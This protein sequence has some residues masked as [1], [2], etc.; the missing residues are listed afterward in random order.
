MKTP[1][2]RKRK[3]FTLVEILLSV[4]ILALVV[5]FAS[6]LIGGTQAVSSIAGR[7]SDADSEAR[8]IFNRMAIDFNAIARRTDVNFY[9]HHPPITSGSSINDSFYFFSEAPGYFANGDPQGSASTVRD[10]FSLVGYRVSDQISGNTRFQLERLGRG[11]HWATVTS[12]TSLGLPCMPQTIVATFSTAISDPYN[13]SSNLAAS[14]TNSPNV[15]E[16]DV[17][18]D[19]VFRLA[20]CFLLSDGTLSNIPVIQSNGLTNTVTATGPPSATNDSNSSPA[21]SAGSRWYDTNAEIAYQCITPSAGAAVW[22]PLGLQDVQA[23][24]VAIGILDYRGR[25]LAAAANTSLANLVTA[26]PVSPT[27]SGSSCQTVLTSATFAGSTGLPKAAIPGVRIYQRYF[28][29]Q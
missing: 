17:V 21:Y 7:R 12:G 23:V 4:T 27:L 18:G 22:Q 28:Y 24:V 8:M 16:W 26:F 3:A 19:E 20:F 29:V 6:Q 9:F 1:G 10:T 25:T 5:V 13:N 15:P 14:G 11:L 2:D